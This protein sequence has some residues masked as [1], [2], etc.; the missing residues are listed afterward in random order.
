MPYIGHLTSQ[1]IV[2]EI[3]VF[4]GAALVVTSLIFFFFFRS[5]RA[6]FIS[7][8]VV[9]IGVMWAFGTLRPY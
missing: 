7:M 3:G 4:I 1:N 6:T 8:C 5:F 9:I 2:D